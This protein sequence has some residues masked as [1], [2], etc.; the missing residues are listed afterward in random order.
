MLEPYRSTLKV[1][2]L[3]KLKNNK[4]FL[5]KQMLGL[6]YH[7]GSAMTDHLINF[8]G[9]KNQLAAMGIKFDEEIQ[10][11]F[12]LGSLLDSWEILR[13]YYQILLQMV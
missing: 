8:Q 12:L 1:C 7:D 13:T 10:G 5:I 11:L 2:M 9:I 3:G 6:K 4:M